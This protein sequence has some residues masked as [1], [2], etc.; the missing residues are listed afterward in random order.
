MKAGHRKELQTNA[1]ADA[2]GRFVQEVRARPQS[3][4]IVLWVLG[5]LAAVILVVWFFSRGGSQSDLWVKIESDS[6][7]R[8]PQ[9]ALAGLSKVAA[10]SPKTMP[11]RTARFQEARLLL[12]QS[13]QMLGTADRAEAVKDL[14]RARSLFTQLVNETG[15][16]ALLRQEALLGA[17]KAEE[18][19]IGVPT[20]EKPEQA[21]GSVAKALELYKKA[22]E[23]APKD[24][25]AK[26]AQLRVKQLQD[27][28]ADVEKFYTELNKLASAPA[29]APVK[30]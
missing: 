10:D 18:A 14:V 25:L 24:Y 3:A 22:A 26:Q 16:D 19:L 4:S 11:G 1:L 21:Y 5:L 29:P 9:E 28:A 12:P 27:N 8:T 23:I 2:M 30:P 6:Y 20:V 15:D 13:L 7:N 17:A